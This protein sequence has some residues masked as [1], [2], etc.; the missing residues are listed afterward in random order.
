MPWLHA[1]VASFPCK[2]TRVQKGMLLNR[3]TEGREYPSQY[4]TDS[5][6]SVMREAWY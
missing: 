6:L 5:G 2:G 3:F 1:L 4:S